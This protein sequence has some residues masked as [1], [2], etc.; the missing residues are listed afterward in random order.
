MNH[1]NLILR[2]ARIFTVDDNQPWAQSVAC[3]QGRILAVGSDGHVQS[4]EGKDTE[5]IDLD[6]KLVLPGFID[7]HVHLLQYACQRQQVCLFGVRTIEEV[8]RRLQQAAAK[9]PPGAWILGW[10]WDELHWD[11]APHRGLLDDITPRNPVALKRMDLHTWW[12]NGAAMAQAG[13]TANTPNPPESAIE[14]DAGGEPTGVLREWN[15]IALVESH[16]PTPTPEEQ[17]EWLRQTIHEAHQLGITSVHDQRVKNEGDVSFRLFQHLLQRDEL[18]LRIHMNIAAESLDSAAR[19]GLRPGFGGDRLWIGHV[20][21]FADGSMGSRTALML[22]PYENQPNNRG[23]EVLSPAQLDGM[24]AKAARAGFPLSIHAIGDRAVRQV[25]DAYANAGQTTTT[26]P[27]RIEHVQTIHPS[28]LP[29]LGQLG[30]VAAVQP[31]HLVTDWQTA[32][33]VWGARARRAYSFRSL[34]RHGITMAFGSDAPVAPWNP[35]LGIHAAITRQDEEGMPDE[36]WYAAERLTLADA[37]RAYTLGS[38]RAAGRQSCQG[39][40]TPGKWADLIALSHDLFTH[41]TDAIRETKVLLTLF[42]GQIV[43]NRL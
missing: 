21:A 7:S 36:G 23:V 26:A 12:V 27:H 16:I 5:V 19:L 42:D 29:R 33:M 41:P 35:L 25:I 30:I 39:S 4:W 22:D 13:I 34:L 32:D 10:G 28:D 8:R 9:T 38:A 40:V 18:Q 37:V 20:K 24:A 14:R 43:H 11:A 15:A 1:A 6:G 3:G 2:N 31:V 17:C